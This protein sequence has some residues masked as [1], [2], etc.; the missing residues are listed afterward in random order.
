MLVYMFYALPFYG[1]AAYALIFPGC[2]WLPDWALVFA[3]AIGQVRRGWGVGGQ[4]RK[5]ESFCLPINFFC[6][7]PGQGDAGPLRGPSPSSA[8]QDSLVWGRK[9]QTQTIPN[10]MGSELKRG[11]GRG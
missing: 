8:P 7:L 11:R 1:L 9:S 2:S 3:G 5:K 4:V 10:P 6:A